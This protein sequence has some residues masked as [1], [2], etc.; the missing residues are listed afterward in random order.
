M[1]SVAS[2]SRLSTPLAS[3]ATADVVR[4]NDT[5]LSVKPYP[6]VTLT[7]QTTVTTDA[8]LGNHFRLTGTTARTIAAPTN[9]TDGQVITYEIKASSGALS[10]TWNAVFGYG[11]DVTALTAIAAG[12]TDFIQWVYCASVTKWLLIGYM[13]GFTT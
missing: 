2:L 13:K 1:S 8:S 6:P 7:D 10:H 11:S 9:P 12:K 4:H 3:A 5:R